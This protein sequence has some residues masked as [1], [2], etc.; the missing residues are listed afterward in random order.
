MKVGDKLIAKGL[1]G[2]PDGT[3]AGKEYEVV[4]VDEHADRTFFHIIN[5]EG[6]K[7][8]PVSTVFEKAKR[9]ASQ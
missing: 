3:T 2:F 5:D 4:T 7:T 9:E 1:C 6:R 8:F